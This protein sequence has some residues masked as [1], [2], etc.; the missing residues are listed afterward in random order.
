MSTLLLELILLHTP[1]VHPSLGHTLLLTNQ[2]LSKKTQD[3]YQANLL[4]LETLL[5]SYNTQPFTRIPSDGLKQWKHVPESTE[6]TNKT[7]IDTCSDR[8]ESLK[9]A[10]FDSYFCYFF[11]RVKLFWIWDEVVIENIAGRQ[12]GIED[13]EILD[14]SWRIDRLGGAYSELGPIHNNLFFAYASGKVQ[15]KNAEV[16]GYEPEDSDEGDQDDEDYEDYED[17]D[18]K[19]TLK[20]YSYNCMGSQIKWFEKEMVAE[21]VMHRTLFDDP[22]FLCNCCA[23]PEGRDDHLRWHDEE[24][25]EVYDMEAS[26]ILRLWDGRYVHLAMNGTDPSDYPGASLCISESL[27]E[28]FQ[29][30]PYVR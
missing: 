16:Y 26:L 18:N 13:V 24:C 17:E 30:D 27:T 25:D 7:L 4:K 9:K 3:H 11:E 28:I 12:E 29:Q 1:L 10:Y 20:C 6:P 23:N 2:T 14:L 8:I 21:I 22:E 15:K 19:N 5:F